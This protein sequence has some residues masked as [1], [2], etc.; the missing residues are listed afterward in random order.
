MNFQFIKQIVKQTEMLEGKQFNI[1][2]ECEI[3]F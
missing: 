1:G 3:I 2:K